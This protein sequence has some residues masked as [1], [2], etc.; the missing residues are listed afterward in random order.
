MKK[1]IYLTE[2]VCPNCG[3]HKFVQR[4]CMRCSECKTVY[5]I[6]YMKKFGKKIKNVFVTKE[7]ETSMIKSC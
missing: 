3:D 6:G 4:T 1:T 2:K 5:A 7:T